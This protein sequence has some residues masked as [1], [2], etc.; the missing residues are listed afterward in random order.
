MIIKVNKTV[1]RIDNT[2]AVSAKKV[3]R[4]ILTSVKEESEIH[5]ISKYYTAFVVMMYILSSSILSELGAE[6]LS[7]IAEKIDKSD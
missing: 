4:S 7:E 6:S 1:Y 3:I 2:L 5:G